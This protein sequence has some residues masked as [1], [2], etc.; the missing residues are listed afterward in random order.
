MYATSL[1]TK[2]LLRPKTMPGEKLVD[3]GPAANAPW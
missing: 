3:L 2:T 1:P